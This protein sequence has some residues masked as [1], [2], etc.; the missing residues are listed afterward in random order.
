MDRKREPMT[1]EELLELSDK[2]SE[3]CKMHD[4]REAGLEA[5]ER[6][7]NDRL[8][9]LSERDQVNIEKESKLRDLEAEL[10][11]IEISLGERELDLKSRELINRGEPNELKA[12]FERRLKELKEREAE[13]S[14]LLEQA[15][16]IQTERL[17]RREVTLANRERELTEIQEKLDQRERDLAERENAV[18]AHEK[19]LRNES[20][21]MR[22]WAS[23]LKEMKTAAVTK[24]PSVTQEL[25]EEMSQLRN[26]GNVDRRHQNNGSGNKN[27]PRGNERKPEKNREEC[28]CCGNVN[29]SLA[30]CFKFASLVQ[31]RYGPSG[32][33]KLP[34]KNDDGSHGSPKQVQSPPKNPFEVA[35]QSTSRQS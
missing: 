14:Q 16:I 2:L 20:K 11:K 23:E 5:R 1:E 7:L 21:L 17:N 27:N 33:S 24:A 19:E 18:T 9:D 22:G 3:Q 32:N 4:D 12:E 34:G 8:S 13:S 15:K 35:H 6:L 29:H 28:P 26:S 25:K 10:R 30:N 31:T